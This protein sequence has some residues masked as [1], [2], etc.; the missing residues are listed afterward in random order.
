MPLRK[1]VS[2]TGR[3]RSSIGYLQ[4]KLLHILRT[5]FGRVLTLEIVPPACRLVVLAV[6]HVGVY[7][8]RHARRGMPQAGG[9][10]RQR[11]TASQEMRCVGVAQ[12]GEA[13]GFR[14]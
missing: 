14:E 11:Y 2:K 4:R 10:D 12:G 5:F 13:R 6:D 9:N 8:G 1:S 3:K 7:F